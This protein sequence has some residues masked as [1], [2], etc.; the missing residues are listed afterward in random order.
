M[1][2]IKRI[3]AHNNSYGG[4]KR[5]KN[6]KFSGTR[7]MTIRGEVVGGIDRVQSG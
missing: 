6:G 1:E 5:L 3:K 4:S 2:N 7:G